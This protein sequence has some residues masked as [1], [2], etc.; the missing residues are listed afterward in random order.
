MNIRRFLLTLTAV[1]A[2][3]AFAEDAPA[4]EAPAQNASADKILESV[5]KYFAELPETLAEYKGQPVITRD[6][7]SA[8]MMPQ[9]ENY[10]RQAEAKEIQPTELNMVVYS[11]VRNMLAQKV[12]IDACL[13]QGMKPDVD[14][15]KK[16][17]EEARKQYGDE[18]FEAMV[19]M[20]GVTL[21]KLAEEIA[22]HEMI[23]KFREDF[24]KAM[25][26]VPE[27]EIKKFYEDNKDKFVRDKATF[28]ASH[29]LVKF[30]SDEPSETEDAAAKEKIEGLKKQ[31]DE[32]AD[33]A[34]L[35]KSSSDCP[36]GKLGGVLGDQ[37][38]EFEEG[39]M[40]P[41]FEEA[42]KKLNPGEIS[43]PVKTQFG[44]HLIKAGESKPAG[45]TIPYEAMKDQIAQYLNNQKL[46]EG[47]V[48]KIE[49]LKTAGDG[50]ILLP[51][52]QLPTPPAAPA[53]NAA[54]AAE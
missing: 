15:A 23:G 35:A 21:D 46:A 9:M 14:A 25:G 39:T 36:S 30:P 47:F 18:Q 34:E 2:I 3:A 4:P 41:E 1:F 42:L 52:P 24:S 27:E 45:G 31:L 29:I 33:F 7:V 54:P 44:Y 5:K 51:E 11:L 38:G 8:L 20:Q 12:L 43:A 19:K 17:L 16:T 13:A 28:K 32:G 10:V 50:K 48:A 49:E 6:E 40:V 26:P 53:Q 22:N 37:N